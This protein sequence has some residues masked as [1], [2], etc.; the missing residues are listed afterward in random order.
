[1][2]VIRRVSALQITWLACTFGALV[3]LPFAVLLRQLP[4]ARP[5]VIGWLVYLALGP[6]ALGFR[7][8]GYALARTTAGRMGSTTYLVAPIAILLGWLLLGETPPVL[9]VVGGALCLVGVSIARRR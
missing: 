8:W 5:Y 4:H 7:T 1:M 9:A 6:M 3:C 2:G